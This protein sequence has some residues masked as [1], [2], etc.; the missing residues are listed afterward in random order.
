[1]EDDTN[2]EEK[3]SHCF[4][5]TLKQATR[6]L[7]WFDHHYQYQKN[8]GATEKNRG[9]TPESQSNSSDEVTKTKFGKENIPEHTDPNFQHMDIEE[10]QTN[11]PG[12][13]SDFD[14]R[15]K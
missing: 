3:K 1:M 11:K 6:V 5:Y 4:K 9:E 10:S 13:L 15:C 2:G 14:T 8:R 12:S 7:Q